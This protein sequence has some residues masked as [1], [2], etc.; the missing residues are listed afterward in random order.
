MFAICI[1]S[2][3]ARGLGHLYRSLTL[4]DGLR[5][6]G[7]PLRFLVNAHPM[8]IDLIRSQGY[9][10]SVI[11]LTSEPGWESAWLAAHPAVK[12]WVNDRLDTS[13]AHAQRVL[14]RGVRFATFDDRGSG[15]AF[16]DLHVAALA[17][18]DA[19]R[20]QGRRI[21]S[22]VDYLMLDPALA[23]HRRQRNTADALLVT[24]GGSDTW[25]VTPR[26]MEALLSLGQRASIVLGPS[27]GHV[28]EVDAV[29]ARAPVGMFT[30]H[31]GGVPSL[32]DEMA[33]HDLAI[34]GGGMTPFQANAM[35]LPCIVVANET[36]EIPVGQALERLGGSVFAGFHQDLDL[37][38]LHRPL[39]IAQMSAA[40]LSAVDLRGC[41]RVV[42][43][44]VALNEGG[45]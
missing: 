35:G 23:G 28:A 16:A 21:L 15:A 2:S 3:H 34:T 36:F 41:D 13:A 22:G 24:L 42:E 38:V 32:A 37:S 14:S 12:V 27:F 9:E 20:L 25:G 31:R 10:A 6:R 4:A 7:W 45:T 26:I 17:F 11:D 30:V 19:G 29:L 40:G 44:L 43:A 1:E 33:R 39:Q 5:R 18:G 8:S